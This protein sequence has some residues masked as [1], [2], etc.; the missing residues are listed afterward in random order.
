MKLIS[1][2]ILLAKNV[3]DNA[4]KMRPIL[5]AVNVTNDFYQATD[6]YSVIRIKRDEQEIDDFPKT[7]FEPVIT[8]AEM[9]LNLDKVNT[10]SFTKYKWLPIL[11]NWMLVKETENEM[12]LNSID[13]QNNTLTSLLKV[14][15]KYPDLWTLLEE[16]PKGQQV[17]L[18]KRLLQNLLKSFW[19]ENDLFFHLW[20][21]STDPVH[22]YSSNKDVHWIIMPLR[23]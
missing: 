14:D 17:K 6:S 3:A 16:E 22:I 12:F 1:K 13:L 8:D 7:W 23:K 20:K 19:D 21:K 10:K 4:S 18:S 11:Q 5:R 2:K 15:W 9:L